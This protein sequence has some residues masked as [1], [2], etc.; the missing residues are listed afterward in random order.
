MSKNLSLSCKSSE[1]KEE[2][3]IDRDQILVIDGD[4]LDVSARRK[5]NVAILQTYVENGFL[6]SEISAQTFVVVLTKGLVEGFPMEEALVIDIKENDIEKDCLNDKNVHQFSS[7]LAFGLI[8][9]I[10]E[11][12]D[13]FIGR[14]RE[15]IED[16]ESLSD[17]LA[18]FAEMACNTMQKAMN[19]ENFIGG[20]EGFQNMLRRAEELVNLSD[21]GTVVL[22]SIAQLIGDGTL[23]VCRKD[24][25]VEES[26]L[27]NVVL[28][29]KNAVFITEGA[30]KKWVLPQVASEDTPLILLK[31]ALMDSGYLKCYHSESSRSSYQIKIWLR[32]VVGNH[33]TQYVT[34]IELRYISEALPDIMEV[35]NG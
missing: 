24:G 21:M 7:Y 14:I 32:D 22:E 20:F 16:A 2:V 3:T 17:R 34:A 9:S 1:L 35:L 23:Q 30:L 29:D 28:F 15:Y 18:L 13:R 5:Q 8:R 33:Y 11:N 26:H 19:P 6:S 31:R 10:E 4:A 27:D 12:T 25:S